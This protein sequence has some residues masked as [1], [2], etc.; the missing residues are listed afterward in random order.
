M[1]SRVIVLSGAGGGLILLILQTLFSTIGQVIDPYDIF[2]L[3]GMRAVDDPIMI[4][5]FAYP[6]VFAFAAAILFHAMEPCLPKEIK[7]KGIRFGFLLFLI[8]TVPNMFVIFTS[9]NYPLGFHIGNF[10][11]G[12]IGYP[13]LGVI[14]GTLDERIR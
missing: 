4:F 10:L 5:F 8:F 11:L 6:F 14:F 3:G 13:L 7:A 12:I 2:T 1:N 9:M